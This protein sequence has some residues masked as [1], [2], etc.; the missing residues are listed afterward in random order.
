MTDAV[1]CSATAATARRAGPDGTATDRADVKSVFGL[2][3]VAR[4]RACR[5]SSRSQPPRL[6]FGSPPTPHARYTRIH[7]RLGAVGEY[8]FYEYEQSSNTL[9]RLGDETRRDGSR[10]ACANRLALAS[11]R[12]HRT[13]RS[14]RA[15]HL[16][17]LRPFILLILVPFFLILQSSIF[18]YHINL[19]SSTIFMNSSSSFMPFSLLHSHT[20][21]STVKR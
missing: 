19:L 18:I 7:A 2:G 14:L 8:V 9:H 5:R 1:A 17:T 16:L 13:L 11:W 10:S 21:R 3:E 4:A 6:P 12:G 15:S 20:Y